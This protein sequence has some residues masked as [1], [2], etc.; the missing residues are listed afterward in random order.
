[1]NTAQ[2]ILEP[3]AFEHVFG[4]WRGATVAEFWGP[5]N[6]G[7]LLIR[8]GAERL[9]EAFGITVTQQ[10]GAADVVFYGGGGNM[11][12]LYPGTRTTRLEALRVARQAGVP[13][14]VLPQSW[15]G[16]E[17]FEADMLFAR[18]HLSLALCPRAVL[19][20]DLGLAYAPPLKFSEPAH[21]IGW[22][23]RT[24]TE[25]AQPL[26]PKDSGDPAS[27]AATAEDYVRIAANYRVVHTDRL[28]FA[29]GAMIAGRK[30]V[31]YANSYPKNEAMFH[32]WLKGRCCEWGGRVTSAN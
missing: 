3:A 27:L 12:P 28:H 2:S 21:E 1:M 8:R 17:D 31:L 4:R 20:P 5:G 24:D 18:E 11:G 16:P 23:M 6:V 10:A 13:L 22:F 25:R 15:T 32:L 19:A 7:D 14:V 30:A 29:I 9:Y 26:V